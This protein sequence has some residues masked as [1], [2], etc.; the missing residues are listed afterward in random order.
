MK[1][2]IKICAVSDTHSYQW[3]VKIPKCDIFIF[4]GDAGLTDNVRAWDFYNW[5]D[6]LDAC[7]KVIVMGN[8]D[9]ICERV[10]K[11]ICKEFFNNA[12]YL[13]NQSVEIE[14]IKIWGS[15]FSKMFNNWYFM[16]YD[17]ELKE[18]WDTIPEDTDIVVTHGPAFGWLDRVGWKNEGSQTLRDRLEEIK[19]KYHICGHIHSEHNIVQKRNTIIVNAS[20][21]DNDY[22]M[23]F[24]PIVF[25]YE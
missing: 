14:G 2:N 21:L 1:K 11:E 22:K 3:D 24:E 13:E 25:D 20:I 6:N 17:N 9:S 4:A 15:P 8:H 5:L 18:I 7:Y 12:I 16:R 23:S 10:G 19:P